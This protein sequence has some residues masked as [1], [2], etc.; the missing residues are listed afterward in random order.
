M[1]VLVSLHSLGYGDI[2]NGA[3]RDAFSRLRVSDPVTIF[4]SQSQYDDGT[5]DK[6]YHVT[7]TGGTAAHDADQSSVILSTDTTPGAGVI[8]QTQRYMR[9]QPGK[10]Q[11]VFITFDFKAIDGGTKKVGYFD[12]ENGFFFQ[13]DA[14]GAAT[15]V[16]RS[17]A[18]GS[19]VDTAV[20]MDDWNIDKFDGTGPSGIT[21]D[22]AKSQIMVID[23]QW[24]AVGQVRIGADIDGSIYYA[25]H[26]HWAN[27]GSGVY[28]TTAN[29]PVRYELW[30]N[31]NATEFQTICAAVI[32][33]GGF[34]ADLGHEHVTPNDGVVSCPVSAETPIISI[35]PRAQFNGITNRGEYVPESVSF[36]TTTN[37]VLLRM[38][39]GSTL[40]GEAWV[41]ADSEGGIE[42]DTVASVASGGH[43]TNSEFGAA[44]AGG[45][46]FSTTGGAQSSD[47]IFL[48]LDVSG[49]NVDNSNFTVVGVGL[50]GTSNVYC[51]IHWTEIK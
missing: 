50:G 30:G 27:E 41:T 28:M 45:K 42:F 43:L 15:L 1:G 38:Y 4:D 21:W 18:S 9:Y 35:R 11:L 12:Q 39:H 51:N 44:A 37:P 3:G 33:E 31:G 10:S 25:H 16:R 24:L 36:Y 26:F 29:L 2:E 47:R 13:M 20:A 7:T 32:S 19:V 46:A 6:W 14:A 34:V 17:K 23:L 48:T 5:T 22:A 40:S 8:R 49:N